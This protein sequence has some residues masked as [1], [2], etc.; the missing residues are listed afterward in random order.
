MSLVMRA[1]VGVLA[2][3]LAG[4]GIGVVL[5]KHE[6]R[7][8]FIQLQGLNNER[9][10]L[11]IEWGQLKLEQSAWATHGRVEQTARVGLRMVIPRPDEVRIVKPTTVTQ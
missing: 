9:D 10:A 3:A 7:D 6:A 11:E 1:G 8:A 2:L 4:T 5:A